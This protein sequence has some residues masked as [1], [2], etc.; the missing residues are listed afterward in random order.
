V[1]RG[2]QRQQR[3]RPAAAGAIDLDCVELILPGAAAGTLH[4][5]GNFLVTQYPYPA[6]KPG[7]D[8]NF[9]GLTIF[10][11]TLYVTKGSASK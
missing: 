7:K 6:D 4:V 2:R 9:R 1:V 8:N 3:L 11:N 10:D 5:I